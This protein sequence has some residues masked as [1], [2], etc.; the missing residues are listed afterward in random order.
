MCFQGKIC[1]DKLES[2][3]D[4]LVLPTTKLNI[5][6]PIFISASVFF[7]EIYS[8]CY[9]AGETMNWLDILRLFN[10]TFIPTHIATATVFLYQHFSWVKNFSYGSEKRPSDDMDIKA[11]YAGHTLISTIVLAFFY[12][13]FSFGVELCTQIVLLVLQ[14]AYM[15][16]LFKYGIRDKVIICEEPI[17]NVVSY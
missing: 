13:V 2:E 16:I 9:V 17:K 14:V 12:V 10:T 11:R 4:K 5:W 7:V 8:A 1:H 15:W 6:I 3:K